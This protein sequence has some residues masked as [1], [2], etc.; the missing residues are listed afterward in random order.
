MAVD[1]LS[2]KG[3]LLLLPEMVLL[4]GILAL[5]FITNLGDAKIRIPLTRLRIPAL[6]GGNRF[7]WNS[8]PRIPGVVTIFTLIFAIGMLLQSLGDDCADI[9]QG[10][11]SE[12]TIL[13]F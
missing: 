10:F 12:T 1:V 5:F 4:T 6:L 7:K 13:T 8:D 11:C 9:M 3:G 2:V